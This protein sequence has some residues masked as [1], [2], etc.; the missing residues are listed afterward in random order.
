MR[1]SLRRTITRT[2]AA[3]TT[4]A[5]VGS[6]A[7][8]APAEASAASDASAGWLADQLDGGLVVSEFRDQDDNWQ[9]YTDFGLTLDVYYAFGQLDARPA[10]RAAILDAIEPRAGEYY[11]QFGTR[12]P[13]AIG[14]LLTAVELAGGDPETYG[15]ADG[16]PNLVDALEDLVVTAGPEEGRAKDDP[17]GPFES[18]NTFTQAY[19]AT[20]LAGADADRAE[21]VSEF[22][23]LQQCP[24]G[25]FREGLDSA[26]G[27]CANAEPEQR[28]PS[29]DATATAAIA[30]AALALD[31]TLS[32]GLRADAAAA[33]KDA[34]D[35]L[36]GKQKDNGAF[37]GNGVVNTNSTGLAASALVLAG[38]NKKATKAARW[39]DQL[40]VTRKL[41][42]TTGY[43][44]ADLGA[45]AYNAAAFKTGKKKGIT[46][47]A[48]Y[49]WRRATAQAA[50]ALDLL[51]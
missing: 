8:L 4:V 41:V 38:K 27:T 3:V 37:V 16:G 1:T 42:R 9:Q 7:L 12:F 49:E 28:R 29:V 10:K 45:I 50:P 21:I 47:T 24:A 6:G 51:G 34:V 39:I 23:L 5:V 36:V 19:V 13:G 25:F 44:A 20:A 17:T 22:L 14:K 11:D 33:S 15:V 26:D 46:R 32:P 31:D 2:A 18:S 40:R 43:K 30:A 48:R 35:W